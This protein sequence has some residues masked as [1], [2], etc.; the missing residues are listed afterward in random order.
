M[1]DLIF[2]PMGPIHR[3]EPRTAEAAPKINRLGKAAAGDLGQFAA[4]VRG[5]EAA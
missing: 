3:S 1:N 2:G 4:G 5:Q